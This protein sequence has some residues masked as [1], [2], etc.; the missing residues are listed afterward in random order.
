MSRRSSFVLIAVAV[1]AVVAVCIGGGW[2]WRGLL[3]MHGKH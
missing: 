2:L 1:L 3:A